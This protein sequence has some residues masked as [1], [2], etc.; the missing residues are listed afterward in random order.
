MACRSVTFHSIEE[1]YDEHDADVFLP[2]IMDTA[3]AA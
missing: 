1:G 3:K 2:K